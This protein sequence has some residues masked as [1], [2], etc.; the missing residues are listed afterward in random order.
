MQPLDLETWSSLMT[1]ICVVLMDK[2][3]QTPGW[4]RFRRK[5]WDTNKALG[6][7]STMKKKS[8]N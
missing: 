4:R 8:S 5:H 1:M 7:I 2:Q 3:E 6:L